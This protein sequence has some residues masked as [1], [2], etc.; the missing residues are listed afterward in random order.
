M[1]RRLVMDDRNGSALLPSE[2]KHSRRWPL[3]AGFLLIVVAASGARLLH[4]GALQV[5]SVSLLLVA[6]VIFSLLLGGWLS[7][8]RAQAG[9][10]RV[11]GILESI[12]DGFFAVD[13]EWR[14]VYVNAQAERLVGR[15]RDQLL[16]VPIWEAFPPLAGSR[17]DVE[18]QTAR[19]TG[20]AVHFE[21]YY[22]PLDTWFETHA[23]PSPDGMSIYIRDVSDRIRAEQA[24]HSRVLQQAAIARVGQMALEGKPL[25]PL[26]DEAVTQLAAVFEVELAKVLECQPDGSLL[27]RA[28]VGWKPGLVGAHRVAASRGSQAGYTLLAGHPVVVEDLGAERRFRGQSLLTEHGAVSGMSVAI[29]GPDGPYGILAVHSTRRRSFSGED[30]SFLAGMAQVLGLAIERS[31]ATGALRDSEL[32]FRQ[33]AENMRDVLFVTDIHN[34]EPG[35]VNPAYEQIRGRSVDSWYR[36]PQSWLDAVHPEDRAFLPSSR[37]TCSSP[38]GRGSATGAASASASASPSSTASQ[39]PTA[40]RSGWSRAPAAAAGSTS[41]FPPRGRQP[42]APGRTRKPRARRPEPR[43]RSRPADRTY[44]HRARGE[45]AATRRRCETPHTA[46]AWRPARAPSR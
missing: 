32:R 20:R 10:A 18:Y 5:L 19:R 33:L 3:A 22:G 35:Y 4:A 17:W 46:G 7:G 14:Y 11:T 25:Q 21:E 15:T 29:H 28:G 27:L 42:A 43:P 38:T 26:F 6:S 2:A 31:Q 13:R 36:D 9:R 45:R 8:R 40:A 30:V 41:R 16:G 39:P 1:L 24:L 12:S 34:R 37:R 23:Y 44:R